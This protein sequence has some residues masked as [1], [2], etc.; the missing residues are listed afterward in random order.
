[1]C[2]PIRFLF[3]YSAGH[4]HLKPNYLTY[5]YIGS[6]VVNT[7]VYAPLYSSFT[8]RERKV[9]PFPRPEKSVSISLSSF[10]AAELISAIFCPFSV[11]KRIKI[12][13]IYPVP[14]RHPPR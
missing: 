1:M 2:D 10:I 5:L 7:G 4:T 9:G 11:E 13:R 14:I 3:M 6:S 8:R 12:V